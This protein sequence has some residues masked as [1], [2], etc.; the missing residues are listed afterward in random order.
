MYTCYILPFSVFRML[1]F[2]QKEFLPFCLFLH[3]RFLDTFF[4]IKVPITV[5]RYNEYVLIL[6]QSNGIDKIVGVTPTTDSM[7]QSESLLS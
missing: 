5:L 7:G 6:N 4:I 1:F 2:G 3:G